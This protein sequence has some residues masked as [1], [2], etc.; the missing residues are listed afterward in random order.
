M[1]D[2]ALR[3]TAAR[4]HQMRQIAEGPD[5]L[6]ETL[7]KVRAAYLE[8]IVESKPDDQAGR[9]A[10]YHRL[11]AHDDIVKVMA[12]VIREGWNATK[13]IEAMSKK[14]EKKVPHVA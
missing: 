1:S 4:G 14:A 11:K 7:T 8:V 13:M 9:E 3:A 10:L 6:F 12:D 5:G 2:D